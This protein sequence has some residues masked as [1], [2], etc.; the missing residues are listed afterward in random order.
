MRFVCDSCR[1]Q[2]MISDDKV[3]PKGV[4]VRCKKC[5]HLILVRKT[6][7]AAPAT[8]PEVE[9]RDETQVMMN[10]LASLGA[11][12]DQELT[13]PNGVRPPKAESDPNSLLGASEDEIGAVF[14]SVLNSGAQKIP[15]S[16]DGEDKT[17]AANGPSLGDDGDDRQST[18]VLDADHLRKLAAEAGLDGAPVAAKAATNGEVKNGD[19]KKDAGSDHD[20]YVA[21][22]EKQVGPL[23]KEVVKQKWEA[24]EIAADSLCWRAGFS[25]WIPVSEA[26]ELKDVLA[27]RAN[28][29]LIVTNSMPAQNVV[30]V[31]VESAFSSG[32]VTRTVRSE[33]QV[34]MAASGSPVPDEAPSGWKPSAASA[35]ASLASLA[36]DD[37]ESY[38]KPAA[39][40]ASG[41][42]GAMAMGGGLLDLPSDDSRNGHGKA[43]SSASQSPL[44][45]E[46]AAAV[47][48]P[49][50]QRA[51]MNGQN[52]SQP[53]MPANQYGQPYAPYPMPS[54]Q[55]GNNKTLIIVAGVVIALLIITVG[56]V[57]FATRDNGSQQ[58]QLAVNTQLP[59]NPPDA[60]N[61]QP[62]KVDPPVIAK[63]D[64]PAAKTDEKPADP[65]VAK[66]DDK[67]VVAKTEDKPQMPKKNNF[68]S[69]NDRPRKVAKSED[70]V[71]VSPPVKKEVVREERPSK[72]IV[73]PKGTD[74]EFADMF[75]EKK[76]KKE[77]VKAVSGNNEGRTRKSIYIPPAVG[78]AATNVQDKLGNSDII[79]GVQGNVGAIKKC[80]QEQKAKDASISG[81]IVMRWTIQT[82]GRTSNV[83]V[84]SDQF[85]G[86][87]I[88]SCL[89]QVIKG[90]TFP[91]HK[92]QGPPVDFPFTF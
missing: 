6:Q 19:A 3:G 25:D 87:Y 44:F 9:E 72:A 91:K 69:G 60:V 16:E 31:P 27:P 38:N 83:S 55:G 49:V 17:Q 48:P 61:T 78:S 92:T 89:G 53:P 36:Q 52:Y 24:G 90:M 57:V 81:K 66:T 23:K 1:A 32:G 20:W 79:A 45:D 74:D 75:G 26:A 28:K 42:E 12:I 54:Q 11:S 33:M 43:S 65:A 10:P 35:L 76:P 51:P 86:A 41:G 59:Q 30:S 47:A 71:A 15:G 56:V 80:A 22:D 18:R 82:S 37:I 67:P 68:N 84:K 2:Y 39:S 40:P 13:N 5:S 29:P 21:I 77:E 34:P 63:T 14:D 58:Q 46:P 85:K 8:A 88:G 73:E 50:V 64:T 62:T 4:K 7:D 70:E